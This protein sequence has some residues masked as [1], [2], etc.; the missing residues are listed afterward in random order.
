MNTRQLNQGLLPTIEFEKS[1]TYKS[2]RHFPDLRMSAY[3]IEHMKTKRSSNLERSKPT[4]NITRKL[5]RRST[6]HLDELSRS[7]LDEIGSSLSDFRKILL[8]NRKK[9]QVLLPGERARAL[10]MPTSPNGGL[11]GGDSMVSSLQ[12]GG[13][14]GLLSQSSQPYEEFTGEPVDI[15]NQ[16]LTKL[17]IS[18]DAMSY[19]SHLAGFAGARLTKQEFETQLRR[20]INVN[21]KKAELDALFLQMDED[22]SGLIDGVEFVRYFFRLGNEARWKML[23][24]TKEIQAKREAEKKKRKI[25]EFEKLKKWES[26]QV[27]E[28]T[29]EDY[30]SAMHKLAD[31]AFRWDPHN[32]IQCAAIS[33]FEAFL[34][35]YEFKMQVERSFNL[36]LTGAEVSASDEVHFNSSNFSVVQ[37]GSLISSFSTREGEYCVDGYLFLKK[38]RSLQSLGWENHEKIQVINRMAK[39][40]TLELGQNTDILPKLLGR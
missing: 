25:E 40:R 31:A 28:F 39:N 23:M 4:I 30:D 1:H 37:T 13:A 24:D 16:K 36:R 22:G 9:N 7:S 8:E 19:N 38:F 26:E 6:H 12:G 33:G 17:S 14:S 2:F 18:F 21:L 11:D 5:Q 29:T 20:C 32:Y 27:T 3:E 15:A 10:P 34:S 35:P